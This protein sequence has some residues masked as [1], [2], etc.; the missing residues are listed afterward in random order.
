[1]SLDKIKHIVVLMMENRSLDNMLGYLYA[2]VNN[3]PRHII[4][5]GSSPLYDGLCYFPPR[6]PDNPFWNPTDP[7]FF[8]GGPSGRVFVSREAENTAVPDPDP[9][10]YFA[11]MTYQLFG[12]HTPEP[13]AP[14]QMK[15]FY[16]NYAKTSKTPEQIMQMYSPASQTNVI[17]TLARHYAVSD[18]WF[19]SSP[20]QTWPNRAF[21]HCGSSNGRVNNWPYDPFQYDIPTIFNTLESMGLTWKV[22]NDTEL[23]SLTRAQLP[24]LWDPLLEDHF[25]GFDRFKD[26]AKNGQLPDYTF[27]EPSFQIEPNDDHPPHDIRPGEQFIYDAWY[28]VVTGKNWNETLFLITYDEHGGCYDHAK[29][30]FGAQTPDAASDPGEDGFYFNR[31]GV[32]VPTILI[33][34]YIA[35]GTVFR[36]PMDTPFTP[37]DHTSVLSTLQMWKNIP[38]SAMPQSKR[39][40]AAPTLAPIQTLETPRDDLPALERPDCS[41]VTWPAETLP[42]N[43]LQKSLLLATE[44]RKKGARLTQ[45]EIEGILADIKTRK[46]SGDYLL[47][48]G[49]R[50]N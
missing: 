26:D 10:E 34:P 1:M 6:D 3:K 46:D 33:S 8:S 44:A 50:E 21:V 25:H 45:S 29:T 36:A 41:E 15:G 38:W 48:N 13:D 24:K 47:Q 35:E 12:P 4:P 49:L 16:I 28:A 22:Y 17:N 31:F 20:T 27:L 30:L 2:D 37:F 9:E 32:R 40:P 43:E 5:S 19:S 18:Q 7:A 23:I 14:D 42:P 39:I 11:D